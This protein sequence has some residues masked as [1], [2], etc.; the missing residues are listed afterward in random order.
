MADDETPKTDAEI[1]TLPAEGGTAVA[2]GE[3]GANLARLR[4]DGSADQRASLS[5]AEQRVDRDQAV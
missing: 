1:A 3:E 2:E 4:G 5:R